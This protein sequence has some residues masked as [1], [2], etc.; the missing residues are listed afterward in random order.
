MKIVDRRKLDESM[1][2]PEKPVLEKTERLYRDAEVRMLNSATEVMLDGMTKARIPAPILEFGKKEYPAYPGTSLPNKHT[3]QDVAY[4]VAFMGLN[5]QNVVS[6]RS[7]GL[8]D[9]GVVCIAD[10]IFSPIWAEGFDWT[11]VGRE[12]LET[13]LV[14]ECEEDKVC[15]YHVGKMQ[16]WL[17]EGVQRLWSLGQNGVP[18]AME[19]LVRK[20]QGASRIIRPGR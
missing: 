14:C 19:A 13:Y 10:Y 9:D 12:R 17:E 11:V 4:L 2:V 1:E 8:R 15:E 6:G 20:Q 3:W 18:M 16:E 7:V 5:G